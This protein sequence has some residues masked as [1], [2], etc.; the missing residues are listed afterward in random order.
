MLGALWSCC[1]LE[2]A[3]CPFLDITYE[4]DPIQNI[5]SEEENSVLEKFF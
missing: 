5:S 2:K 1:V 4:E 3:R